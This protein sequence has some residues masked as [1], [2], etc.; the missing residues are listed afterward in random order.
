MKLVLEGGGARAAYS[1]GLVHALAQ[2]GVRPKVVIGTSS[3]SI[4]AAFFASGQT[5]TVV[6]LWGNYVP[7][8]HFI[9][10]RRQLTPFGGPG[11]AVDEMLDDL[12][13]GRS[14]FDPIAA[15]RGDPTLYIA[16]TDVQTGQGVL[17][18]PGP[19]NVIEWLRAS[20]AL[21]VGYNRV[22]RIGERGFIDGG[23]ALPVP[24]D[25]PLAAPC[26]GPTVVVL[27]RKMHTRKPAPNWW[28]RAFIHAIVPRVARAATLRQHDLHNA[29]MQRLSLAVE[30]EEVILINPPDEMPLS[31]FTRDAPRIRAGIALGEE[32]G[33]AIAPRLLG[34]PA[35]LPSERLMSAEL[36]A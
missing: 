13:V 15:T 16:A 23:V 2:A 14:L 18:K 20:L 19:D 10:W 22:V 21:P 8:N 6:D 34:L 26:E 7:G 3:G 25:E 17:V 27:T 29:V 11:L 28:Q 33:R 35:C 1:A 12:M 31:R 30:R 36:R 5:S 4:N 24:F 32:V 9:S